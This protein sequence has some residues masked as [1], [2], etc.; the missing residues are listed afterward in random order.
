MEYK[1]RQKQAV[2]NVVTKLAKI[3]PVHK[4]KAKYHRA[5]S[6]KH[7]LDAKRLHPNLL[8]RLL[9]DP[10]ERRKALKNKAA[11]HETKAELHKAKVN[12][13]LSQKNLSKAK[14]VAGGSA[15]S[16]K[17][18]QKV[19]K[20]KGR[21]WE[22][23]KPVPGKKPYSEDSCEKDTKSQRKTAGAAR[24]ALIGTALGTTVGLLSAKSSRVGD[25]KVKKLLKN[26]IGKHP[27]GSSAHREAKELLHEY[28]RKRP[29][30]YASAGFGGAVS[31]GIL[32]AAL[33]KKAAKSPA[34]QRSEGKSK[35]GGL[36]QKGVDSYRRENP[37]SKLKT[38]VTKD[39]SKL[40]KGG[41]AAAR[42]KSFC[43][44]MSGMR[45]RQAASNNTGEDRLSKSLRKWNC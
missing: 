9:S 13:L 10:V 37:G 38:A 31:G 41:K 32:G 28:H 20:K 3:H 8:A 1:N 30:S 5:M 21:C 43:A 17:M 4:Q 29:A 12:M 14:K 11:K 44:R 18:H 26:E 45:K 35:S 23:Y 42:R 24:N 39:P 6:K 40:K 19:A 16:A 22:G 34:W 25:E 2:Q 27:E 7:A 36:N 15:V 33:S